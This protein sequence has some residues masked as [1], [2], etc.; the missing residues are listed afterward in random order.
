MTTAPLTADQPPA[1]NT[2]ATPG[3]SALARASRLLLL[4]LLSCA[5]L[6]FGSVEPWAWGAM[7]AIVAVMLILWGVD[8]IRRRILMLAWSWSFVPLA[9]LL[10]YTTG[11]LEFHLSVDPASTAEGVL[12]L[13]MCLVLFFLTMQF[14]GFAPDAVWNRLGM[15]VLLYSSL[16]GLL[17]VLQFFSAPGMMYWVFPSPN[18]S[19]GPYIN[20]DHFA[21]LFEMLIPLA[22]AW[23]IST[24]RRSSW[25]LL[26]ACGLLMAIAALLLTGSRG[27]FLA[28]LSEVVVLLAVI[29]ARTPHRRRANLVWGI[30][31]LLV[32]VAALLLVIAPDELPARLASILRFRDAAVTGYRAQ[33]AHDTVR[34]F[35]DHVVAGTGLGTFEAVYPQYQSFVSDKTWP[36]AHN[37][38]VQFLAETG[39]IGGLL[40]VVTLWL[41]FRE[42][43]W[44]R[45]RSPLLGMEDWIQL[46]AFVGCCGLLV[47]SFVDFNLHIPANAAW[48]AYCAALAW[49]RQRDPSQP[50]TVTL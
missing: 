10:G 9:V 31:G 21:G 39:V 5:P 35:G 40:L 1:G 22:A 30:A 4:G 25:S 26:W 38:Y 43:L 47:H 3:D 14:Y 29:L 24:G 41:F 48:F 44:V 8:T 13:T 19:F 32:C 49:C 45:L 42:A 27:G 46:G 20:R 7:T 23:Y 33:V 28:L 34:I 6:A 2:P 12:K 18:T 11:Q 16:L 17:A 50:E 36:Y 15:Y 37:D